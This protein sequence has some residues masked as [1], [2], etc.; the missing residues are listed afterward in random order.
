MMAHPSNRQSCWKA[1]ASAEV[2][3]RF[4]LHDTSLA[5]CHY[6]PYGIQHAVG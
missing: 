1:S 5:N 4:R 6:A 2:H 3:L